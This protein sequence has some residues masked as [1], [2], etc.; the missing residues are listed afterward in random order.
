MC[1]GF[2]V[3][4]DAAALSCIKVKNWYA[5]CRLYLRLWALSLAH[6]QLSLVFFQNLGAINITLR[7]S[8][9]S[10]MPPNLRP[11]C[12]GTPPSCMVLIA[13]KFRK[14]VLEFRVWHVNLWC[15]AF[16]HDIKFAPVS[17]GFHIWTLYMWCVVGPSWNL[18]TAPSAWLCNFLSHRGCCSCTVWVCKMT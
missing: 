12:D 4:T 17:A 7:K 1:Q 9:D 5:F 2:F 11:C 13:T 8:Q 3:C 15:Q 6:Q 14:H 16:R 10:A 18:Q